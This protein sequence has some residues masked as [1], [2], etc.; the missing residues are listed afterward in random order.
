[1]KSLK[2]FIKPLLET[3]DCLQSHSPAEAIDDARGI[4]HLM[5]LKEIA[6]NSRPYTKGVF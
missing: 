5:E 3:G 6:S 4:L 1:M 2:H